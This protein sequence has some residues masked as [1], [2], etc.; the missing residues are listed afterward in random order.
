M[1]ICSSSFVVAFLLYLYTEKDWGGYHRQN[2]FLNAVVS[3]PCP[4]LITDMLTGRSFCFIY[5]NVASMASFFTSTLALFPT[6]RNSLSKQCNKKT[7]SLNNISLFKTCSFISSR[8]LS[9]FIFSNLDFIFNF[10]FL[11]AR[12]STSASPIGRVSGARNPPKTSQKSGFSGES[13]KCVITARPLLSSLS[14]SDATSM[15]FAF[16]HILAEGPLYMIMCNPLS[17]MNTSPWLRESAERATS[18]TR[19]VRSPFSC[20]SLVL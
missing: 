18:F 16:S 19:T 5:C 4:T 9:S 15:P 10:V 14:M 3:T 7:L 12:I 11:S 13:C 2:S 6:Q 8:V 20:S 1:S 17:N